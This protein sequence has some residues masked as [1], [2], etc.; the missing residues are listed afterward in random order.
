M[1]KAVAKEES[2]IA[3]SNVENNT[4][5]WKRRKTTVGTLV[6]LIPWK[7]YSDKVTSVVRLL[8]QSDQGIIYL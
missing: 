4:S 1:F 3:T 5:K 2:T 8:I 7:M 6:S